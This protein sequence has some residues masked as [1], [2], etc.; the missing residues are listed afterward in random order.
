MPFF[1]GQSLLLSTT[2][3]NDICIFEF[4]IGVDPELPSSSY[5]KKRKVQ[6][7]VNGEDLCVC[8]SKIMPNIEY[9]K[10]IN[11]SRD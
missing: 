9:L 4:N 2:I 10:F 5:T 11:V 6:D 7:E 8:S 3:L 1:L